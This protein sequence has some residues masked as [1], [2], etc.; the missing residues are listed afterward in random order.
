[1]TALKNNLDAETVEFSE[2][3]SNELSGRSDRL[4]ENSD[5]C[6]VFITSD[7]GEGFVSWKDVKGD[8]SN[9]Y[10]QKGGDALVK[11]VAD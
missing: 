7:A 8:R 2:W 4:A 5:I 1:M 11:R 6:I 3:P 10:S 9:L